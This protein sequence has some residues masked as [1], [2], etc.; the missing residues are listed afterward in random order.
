MHRGA[1]LQQVV[2]QSGFTITFI[3]KRAGF[4]RSS[5]YNHI[6]DKDLS[7]ET[8]IEYGSILKYDFLKEHPELT[9]H[10]AKETQGKYDDTL[11]PST[12]EQ[13]LQQR[14]AWKEK[15]FEL[16]EKYQ[17]ILELQIHQQNKH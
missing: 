5:F 11:A 8:L 2:A 7:L 13:A 9:G 4:S 17:K 14:D 6:A 16:L 12:I 1:L 10:L 3:T 15:Y